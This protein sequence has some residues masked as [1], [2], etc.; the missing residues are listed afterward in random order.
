MPVR[1]RSLRTGA[2]I[3]SVVWMMNAAMRLRPSGRPTT[4]CTRA[5]ISSH[6][7][8]SRNRRKFDEEERAHGSSLAGRRP[9]SEDRPADAGRA[10]RPPRP[11]PRIVLAHAHRQRRAEPRRR[12]PAAAPTSA[13]SATNVGPRVPRRRRPAARPSSGRRPAGP[14]GRGSPARSRSRSRGLEA[15][16]GRRRRR[17]S[18]GAAPAAAGRAAAR[19]RSGRAARA[20]SSE[21]TVSIT[22][23]SST[24][25]RAL[26][27]C[28]GPTRCQRGAS[29]AS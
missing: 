16:L 9:R 27:D 8:I 22:S 24:A 14:A 26:F 3:G 28:S 19:R 23:N 17:R 21:S 4:G 20:R 2:R 5:R 13:R 18:P 6:R 1:G 25:R 7:P 11:R 10:S 29:P 12:A 15:R